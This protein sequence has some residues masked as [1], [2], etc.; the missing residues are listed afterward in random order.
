MKKWVKDNPQAKAERRKMQRK[1]FRALWATEKDKDPAFGA[2]YEK[3]CRDHDARATEKDK[4]PAFGAVYEKK[5]RDH[6]ARQKGAKTELVETLARNGRRS[7]LSLEK[8]VNNWCSYKTIER[9]LKSNLDFGYYSQNVRPL[10]SEGNRLKQ[11]A[12]SKH[13]RNRWGLPEG[14]KI[15]W[16]MRYY[17]TLILS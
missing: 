16:T 6:D 2:V 4:D 14:M 10:L 12:F 5:C 1:T 11:V 7:F 3:K 8:A 17:L 13:V 9:F 15:L